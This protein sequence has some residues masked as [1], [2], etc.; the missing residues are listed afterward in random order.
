MDEQAE[1]GR[2]VKGDSEALRL[3]DEG[4]NNTIICEGW[5]F[6]ESSRNRG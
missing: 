1:E 4:S 5:V 3:C 6:N 2:R